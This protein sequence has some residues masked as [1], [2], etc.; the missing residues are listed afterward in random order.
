MFSTIIDITFK[1]KRTTLALKSI[2]L[3]LLSTVA[4][5]SFENKEKRPDPIPQFW[6][7]DSFFECNLPAIVGEKLLQVHMGDT[8]RATDSRYFD[9]GLSALIAYNSKSRI[10]F[11]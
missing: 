6:V 11:K 9:A 4:G 8:E 3:L 7:D 10:I 1:S 5:V 2:F